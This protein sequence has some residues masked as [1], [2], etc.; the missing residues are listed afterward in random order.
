MPSTSAAPLAR[1][2]SA[3][4]ARNN[5]VLPAPFGPWTRTT[6]PESTTRSTPVKAGKRSS[7]TT[8][9]RKQTAAVIAGYPCYGGCPSRDISARYC[10]APVGFRRFIAGLGRTLIGTGIL[11]LLFVAYELW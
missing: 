2:T 8:A 6:S 9:E 4:Q 5:V 7:S 1:G 10:L 3:A 11:I